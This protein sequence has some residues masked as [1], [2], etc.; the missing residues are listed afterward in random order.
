MPS[1]T[2][3][4][5]RDNTVPVCGGIDAEGRCYEESWGWIGTV[6]FPERF[7]VR[8]LKLHP[9]D[10]D[11]GESKE[12]SEDL[13]LLTNLDDG[14]CHPAVDSLELY[15]RRCVS[16]YRILREAKCPQTRTE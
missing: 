8:R 15:H 5:T 6:K 11:N 2:D 10:I 16:V 3:C 9:E 1:Q 4:Y 7:R 12:K 14:D 13:V